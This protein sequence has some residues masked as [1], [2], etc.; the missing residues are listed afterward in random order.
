MRSRLVRYAVIAGVLCVGALLALLA[1]LFSRDDYRTDRAPSRWDQWLAGIDLARHEFPPLQIAYPLDEALFPP[2]IPAPTFRWKD[3]QPLADNWL[4]RIEF[5]DGKQPMTFRSGA[6]Q[7]KPEDRQWATIKRRS[8]EKEAKVAIFG[9]NRATPKQILSAGEVRISTSKDEV[10][11]PIF[12]R[13]VNLPFAEAVKDPS[14]IRWRLGDVSSKE[15]PPVVLRNIPTCANCHSFSADGS[16]MAMDVDSANDKGSYVIAPVAEEIVFDD[17]KIIT[18]SDYA[19]EDKQ[20]TFGSL[21]QVSPNGKY[22]ICTV[23]DL[24]VFTDM[25]DLAFSQLFFAIQ[26]I[27]VYYHRETR[28]FQAL[29]GADDKAFVQVNA[30]WSPDG[31][32]L[33]FARQ[34]AYPLKT[35]YH[36]Q[37]LLLDHEQVQEFL[38]GG[39][40][41][42]FDLY[43]IPFNGGKGGKPKPLEGASH[44][45]MS[46]YFPKYSPDGKWIV[47]CKAKSFMLLQ[48]DSELYIVPA[49]GGKARRMRGNTSRMNSWHSWSPNGKWLVFSSKANSP[50]TQLF[51]THIDDQ[52]R[53]T[54]P[55]LLEAFS[56]PDRAIN[57]PEFVNVKPG[58]IKRIRQEFVDDESF[59]RAASAALMDGD[60]DVAAGHY[61][62]ALKLNPKNPGAHANLGVILLRKGMLKEAQAQLS[63][64]VEYEPDNAFYQR[65]MGD[66]LVREH[67]PEEAMKYYREALRIDP[68]YT[69]VRL[70]LGLLL[71]IAGKLEDGTAEFAEAVRLDSGNALA[72]YHLARTLKRQGKLDQAVSE[73]RLALELDGDA[74]PALTDLATIQAASEDRKFRNGAEAVKLAVRACVL[75]RYRSPQTLDIL[76]AAYAENGQFPEAIRTGREAL[77]LARGAKHEELARQIAARLQ[78]YL[79]GVPIPAGN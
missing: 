29:P 72:H 70:N 39:K 78:F 31:E 13:E 23:K 64:A 15:P 8:W 4:I 18:W 68:K 55:V 59:A 41:F 74:L 77:E 57:I 79:R 17:P 54:P 33:V 27:L 3:Q 50:Y 52:G 51:L 66:V 6:M 58:A 43:R 49:E 73:Y 61:R 69:E 1:G 37:L 34:K 9:V 16:T 35:V 67:Q 38:S 25:P 62:N 19:R 30:V 56:S 22:V 40:T 20:K 12:Y 46:N 47:F 28:T 76:A 32:T 53:S 26:G 63:K 7:W 44:N 45:G 42:L 14:N 11:A 5:S 21:A 48:P 71:L 60:D 24:S 36:N 75:T 65:N 2:E 10:G